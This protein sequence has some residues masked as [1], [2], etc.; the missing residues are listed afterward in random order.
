M[1]IK[2]SK[3]TAGRV[4]GGS[5]QHLIVALA[6]QHARNAASG[7]AALTDNSSGVAAATRDVVAI[8]ADLTDKAASGSDLASTATATTQLTAV[9]DAIL[10]LATKALAI[11]TT[12]GFPTPITYNGGGTAADGTIDAIGT[13]TGAATGAQASNVNAT[14][15]A[16][17]NALFTVSRFT[18]QLAT[19]VGKD[20]LITSKDLGTFS[21]TVAAITVG[22]GAAASPGVKKAEL[23]A[24]L[25]L[26]ANN[27]ATIAA[28][29]NALRGTFVPEV[30]VVA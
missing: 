8:A 3:S 20:T 16:L 23:D 22:V 12:I 21:T 6:Q 5:N 7:I 29:L 30:V 9:K 26:F 15:T 28:R 1:T 13:T 14:I 25:A 27:I 17:D 4:D 18:S 11:S 24:K 2:L 19:A 10:E